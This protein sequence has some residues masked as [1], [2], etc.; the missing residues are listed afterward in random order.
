MSSR[1]LQSVQS[2]HEADNVVAIEMTAALTIMSVARQP[3]NL[4]SVEPLT[5]GRPRRQRRSSRQRPK[6]GKSKWD[7]ARRAITAVEDDG[8]GREEVPAVGCDATELGGPR[9]HIGVSAIIAVHRSTRARDGFC[10]P[11]DRTEDRCTQPT[12][13]IVARRRTTRIRWNCKHRSRLQRLVT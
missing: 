10:F 8:S 1:S 5:E 4:F 11:S 2:L 13:A 6:P 12:N 3:A 9:S 7:H